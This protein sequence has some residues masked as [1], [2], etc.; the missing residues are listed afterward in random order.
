MEI[1]KGSIVEESL[2]DNLILNHFIITG[3]HITDDEN[4]N[5]RWHIYDV[6]VNK[7]QIIELSKCI[8]SEKWYAHFWSTNKDIIAV[9]RDKLFEFNHE[10]KES[11][12]DAVAY[13]ISIGIPE[14]QLDF[15]IKE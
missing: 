8:K 5:E 4:V 14:E 11:W 9:F 3:V 6:E 15:L 13:G 10:D 1:Y 7:N 2:E 12:R